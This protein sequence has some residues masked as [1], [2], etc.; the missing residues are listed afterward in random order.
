VERGFKMAISKDLASGILF[1]LIGLFM[2]V[3]AQSYTL[4]TLVR[5]GPGYLPT[6]TG[7][8]LILCGLA[9]SAKTLLTGGERVPAV[10][11]RALVVVPASILTFALLLDPAGLIVSTLALVLVA[12]LAAPRP[13]GLMATLA[14]AFV[15]TVMDVLVFWYLLNLPF[16]L[17][18]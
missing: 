5:M 18:P 12:R 3:E 17:W 6:V 2:V 7:A 13:L 4:G 10:S 11:V 16:R 1:L 8:L 14:L 9:L 15:L